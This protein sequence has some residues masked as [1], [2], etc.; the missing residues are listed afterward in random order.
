MRKLPRSRSNRGFTLIELLVVIAI[1]GVLSAMLLPALG[2]AKVKAAAINEINSAR[3]VMLAWHLYADDHNGSV[4][5]GY[6]YGYQAFDRAGTPLEHPI[7]ARYPW[8][9]APYLGHSFEI[10]YANRNRALLQ[11]FAND[12]DGYT[13]AASVFPSL[14]INS[15][16]VGGDDL[17]LAP[18]PQ[19]FERF[20][21]FC[22]LKISDIDRPTDLIAFASARSRFEEGVAEG[23]YRV[24]PPY[25]VQR[26]WAESYDPA[27]PPEDFGFVHPRFALR[28]IVA[29]TDGHAESLGLDQIQDMRRWANPADRPDWTLERRQ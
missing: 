23:Y 21:Y 3:Q 1:I 27:L 28:T 14:G 4:L 12:E 17:A 6:R 29:V 13:Y 9:L 15:V 19:V 5:P 22:V 7:N 10:L 2:R 11:R 16:F 26:I 20:G 24:D 18:G 8:R 25:L